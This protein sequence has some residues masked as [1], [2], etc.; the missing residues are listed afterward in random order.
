[1]T[2]PDF[3]EIARRYSPGD[4]AYFL[5]LRAPTQ[6]GDYDL[7]ARQGAAQAS[8]RIQIRTLV[9]LRQVAPFN[10]A[11]WPR[12]WPLDQDFAPCKNRQTLQDLALA[13]PDADA[14]GFWLSLDDQTLWRQ[15]PP[16]ELPRAHFVNVH[17]G[18]PACGS[19][20]F[21]HGGFYPWQRS[22]RPADYRS[23]CPNCRA[24]FPDNN[25]GV[26]DFTT[27]S[28]LDDGYG[29]SDDTGHLFLF[30]ATYARDQ[31][32]S[33]G[34][35]IDQ[36]TRHLHQT[37]DDQRAAR[38]LALMLL[39]YAEEISYLA[40]VPQFRYG[41]SEGAEKPWPWG[42]VDWAAQADPI[43][44]L[45]R[46]GML[47]YSIDVP[48]ISETLA[49][50]YDAIWPFLHQ[51]E[52]LVARAQARG[53]SVSSSNDIVALIEEMLACQLQCALDGGAA[54]NLP[55]VSQGALVLLRALDRPDADDVL[56]WLYD[57]GP[58]RLRLFGVDNF[59]PDGTPP[60]ATGGYNGIH[61]NGLFALEYQLRALRQLHPS[62]YPESRFPSLVGD[63][64]AA[65]VACAPCEIATIGRSW[66]QFG[67]GSAPGSA[68]QLGKER[69]NTRLEK[70]VFH[71]PLSND[72]LAR[73][74]EFT[75]DAHVAALY[76]AIAAGR[77]PTLGTTI[78]DGVGLAILRTG[79]TPERAALGIVYGDATGH[80]HQDLLDA[81]LFYRGYAF[82]SDLGYPQSWASIDQW[83]AH[84]ATHN[85]AWG[86]VPGLDQGRISGRGRLRRYLKAPGLQILDIE[87]ERWAWN[88]EEQ[89][90]YRPGVSFRRL[91]ALVET[92]GDGVAVVDMTRIQ[93]GAEH[94][95]LCWG[96]GA[97][98]STD[99]ATTA[100][101][102]T[103]AG[104][105]IQRGDL[106]DLP[107]PDYA[108][109]AY[110]DAVEKL[111]APPA[112]R[113]TWPLDS[114]AQLD[115]HQL[116]FSGG[117]TLTA[118]ATA[119]MGQPEE[120]NYAFRPLIWRSTGA[121]MTSIDL[122]FEPRVGESALASAH[123]IAGAGGAGGA[124][125]T[126]AAGRR[127]ALYWSPSGGEA[128]FAD[129]TRLAGPLA[130]EID[131][132]SHCCGTTEFQRADSIYSFPQ[133]VQ[134]GT[135]TSVDHQHC[136]IEIDGLDD[137]AT[138]DRI[139]LNSAGRGR[140]YRVEAVKNLGAQRYRLQLDVTTLLG[141]NQVL[142]VAGT[143]VEMDYH[144]MART[145]Y[146]HGARLR[147]TDGTWAEITEAHNPN[148]G[149]TTVRLAKEL[150][151]IEAG[152]WLEVV[153]CVAGDEVL[154]E[155][156]TNIV[157]HQ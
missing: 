29:Y 127:I 133:A 102:G 16:A 105:A 157:Q 154:F 156:V 153:D 12:R 92:D 58:D 118:R 79:E 111:A 113:G 129:G 36:L 108:A 119:I 44:A 54:S 104:E 40:A 85:T 137:L 42:Q 90:W 66:L 149:R 106:D 89:R 56:C 15:L 125:L 147:R 131:G 11:T 132:Q 78:H 83:E 150:V 134:R 59:F 52:A 99:V 87:A 117:E 1:M 34:A 138:A 130:A 103:V 98:F 22:H 96:C 62:A 76:A 6:S 126:T 140:S 109:L 39:R 32:R 122:V 101:S 84:W 68:A 94:W 70:P 64:R 93:G 37:P 49:L 4:D 136:T 41:P 112:W 95:R 120:S 115:L 128:N 5:Y 24:I 17:Q 135:I 19:A 81:Q 91:L 3:A 141:R 27:G 88:T 23:Q 107:H 33:F 8:A 155:P 7:T 75:A 51:D 50:A 35:G 82:L 53:L 67:D 55:R 45:A 63:P 30:A 146:L 144:L 46:K 142:S 139:V 43:A 97:S 47:R 61:S 86:A 18:C 143:F 69:E 57:R 124:E 65:R 21:R 152:E 123:G 77:H 110:M 10:G 151:G 80:R 100:R 28:H 31:V 25:L 13:A 72:T 145:G 26:S 71:A 48:Y 20:I 14:V 9:E 74:A 73:A 121:A 60:E 2:A 148:N 114:N 116:A 38:Q